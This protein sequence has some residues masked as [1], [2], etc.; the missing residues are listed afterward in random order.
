MV[1]KTNFPI[2]L[3]NHRPGVLPLW[4]C[5]PCNHCWRSQRHHI[6]LIA[7]MGDLGRRPSAHAWL[8]VARYF[9]HFAACSYFAGGQLLIAIFIAWG[10]CSGLRSKWESRK[11]AYTRLK[12]VQLFSIQTPFIWSSFLSFIHVDITNSFCS[13]LSRWVIW[14]QSSTPVVL[15]LRRWIKHLLFR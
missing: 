15:V 6:L 4:H 9:R 1:P 5:Y 7:A 8:R 11:S 14:S 10:T 12:F 2:Q 3:E 13:F